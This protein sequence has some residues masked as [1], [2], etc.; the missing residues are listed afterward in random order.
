MNVHGGG[1]LLLVLFLS[2]ILIG[3]SAAKITE[4]LHDDYC[5]HQPWLGGSC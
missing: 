3:F 4:L 2:G 1:Y 5:L